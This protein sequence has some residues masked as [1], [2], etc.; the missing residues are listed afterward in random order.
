MPR[1]L[2]NYSYQQLEA[3][4]KKDGNT[5]EALTLLK[6][7]LIHRSTPKAKNLLEIIRKRLNEVGKPLPP[8]QPASTPP[9]NAEHELKRIVEFSPPES[10]AQGDAREK[11]EPVLTPCQDIETY[12]ENLK[13]PDDLDIPRVFTK[14]RPPGTRDYLIHMSER[15]HKSSASD[16]QETLTLLINT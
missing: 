15:D 13:I 10:Q 7:E 11:D 2:F 8:T 6:D 9:P 1:P 14:I 4:F 3:L 5:A 12:A 16:F